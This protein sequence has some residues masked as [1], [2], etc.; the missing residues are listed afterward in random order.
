[1]SR[2]PTA[3]AAATILI[4]ALAGCGSSSSGSSSKALT[5]SQW[6]TK[7]DAICKTYNAKTQ[8]LEPAA[9]ATTADVDAAVRKVA[10]LFVEEIGKI[11]K[12]KAP[13]S[14][15]SDVTAM[16]DSLNT[17]ATTLKTQGSAA[18]TGTPFAD[19]GTKAQALGLKECG[20]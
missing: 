5:K 17:A 12:L 19:A 13:S 20:A 10:D 9:D 15:A 14:I 8:A 4:L 3:L 6:T 1:M 18:L 7:A 11:K 16:L 2:I